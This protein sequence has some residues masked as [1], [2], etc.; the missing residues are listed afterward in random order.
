MP[1][2]G[3]PRDQTVELLVK[4]ASEKEARSITSNVA[5]YTL[6]ATITKHSPGYFIISDVFSSAELNGD[7]YSKVKI[8]NNLAILSDTSQKLRRD[9]ILEEAD[10]VESCLRKLLLR[11]NAF[12]EDYYYLFLR[13]YTKDHAEKQTAIMAGDVDPITSQLTFDA[14]VLILGTDISWGQLQLNTP[15]DMLKLID[16]VD[17]L[18][19]LRDKLSEKLKA[20]LVW[21]IISENVLLKQYTWPE[22]AGMVNKIKDL[23]NKAAHF[24]TLTDKDV[25]NAAKY[26]QTLISQVG[27]ANQKKQAQISYIELPDIAGWFKDSIGAQLT[28]LAHAMATTSIAAQS[29]QMEAIRQMQKSIQLAG[30]DKLAANFNKVVLPQLNLG[31]TAA[32][33]LPKQ[34]PK[35]A[36]GP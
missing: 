12:I 36:P 17:D 22:V 34:P 25:K 13:P 29:A 10:N 2:L 31:I 18:K 26:S 9:A 8:A 7:F 20:K 35:S 21:D 4:A 23:R 15:H 30:I 16:G 14:M 1:Q 3:P 5:G 27:E 24:Q 28:E 11:V 19:A 33:Q 32:L 6:N